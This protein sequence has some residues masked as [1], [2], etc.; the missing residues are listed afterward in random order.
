V[1][2]VEIISKQEKSRGD[3]KKFKTH[4]NSK[5]KVIF[6][7]DNSADNKKSFHELS[8]LVSGGIITFV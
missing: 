4:V 8:G 1:I 2:I 7:T 5:E 3:L 6:I